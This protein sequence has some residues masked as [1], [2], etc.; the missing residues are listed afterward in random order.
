MDDV[1]M[2][3]NRQREKG[4]YSKLLKRGRNDF[5]PRRTL[6]P[7]HPGQHCTTEGA[8]SA[9]YDCLIYVL[10]KYRALLTA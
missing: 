8:K 5:T 1:I 2:A 3:R 7:T 9:I 10:S 6:K 4:V